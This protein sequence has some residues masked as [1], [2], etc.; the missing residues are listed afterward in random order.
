MELEKSEKILCICYTNHALDDFLESLVDS[1]VPLTSIV[2]HDYI[3][4]GKRNAT[5]LKFLSAFQG[6]S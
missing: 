5:N 4:T 3:I 2:R 6:L 1:D